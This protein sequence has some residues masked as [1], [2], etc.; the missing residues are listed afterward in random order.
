[1]SYFD[2]M[3]RCQQ[4][5]ALRAVLD[6]GGNQCRAARAMG[7]HR[8]TVNRALRAAGYTPEKLKRMARARAAMAPA[9][10]AALQEQVWRSA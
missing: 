8:N 5:L 1:M 3:R 10:E 6:A 4:V 9:S 2:E 7:V